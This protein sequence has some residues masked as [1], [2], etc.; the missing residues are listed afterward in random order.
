MSLAGWNKR[1]RLTKGTNQ[2]LALDIADDALQVEMSKLLSMLKDDDHR[3]TVAQIHQIRI[4]KMPTAND[5]RISQHQLAKNTGTRSEH[6][7]VTNIRILVL[8]LPSM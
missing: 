3:D 2:C 5:S 8:L 1:V 7:L 4:A 6:T